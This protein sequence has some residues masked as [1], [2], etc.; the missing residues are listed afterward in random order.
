MPIVLMYVNMHCTLES[1]S[2]LPCSLESGALYCVSVIFW[3]IFMNDDPA[4]EIIFG[5]T[6]QIVVRGKK[7]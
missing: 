5:A 2:I 6:L 4:S 7:K 3:V 1:N